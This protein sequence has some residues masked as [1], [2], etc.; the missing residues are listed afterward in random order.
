MNPSV[1]AVHASGIHNMSKAALPS[2][3]LVEGLGVE[4]DAHSGATVKHRSRVRRD[5]TRPNLRQVHLI[6]SELFNELREKGFDVEPGMMGE[7]ITTTGIDLLSLPTGAYLKIGDRAVVEL[8]GLRDPCTQLD[9]L[10]PGLMKAVLDRDADGELIRK[11]G[12][13]GIA[14][15]DGEIRPGDRIRVELPSGV[16]LPL[17]PV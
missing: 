14:V 1:L 5:A 9:G 8:T 7:N 17:L 6:H 13:M 16:H 11:T 3:T 10:I 12:V 4:G 2:I 15:G